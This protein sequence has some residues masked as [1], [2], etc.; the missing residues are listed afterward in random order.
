MKKITILLCLLLTACSGY[1]PQYPFDTSYSE[2]YETANEIAEGQAEV[3]K[4][5]SDPC[6]RDARSGV[7][8]EYSRCNPSSINPLDEINREKEID[9]HSDI[10]YCDGGC[11]YHKEGCDIKG[12][13]GFESGERIYHVPGQEFY[14]ETI[15][16]PSYGERW[17]CTEEEAEAN[18]W[19]KANN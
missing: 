18:G 10:Y 16:N 15:I 14:D 5:D 4:C 11:N 6:C 17:F 13:I 1:G 7:P 2:N 12:N 9:L 3:D 19:R 8:W